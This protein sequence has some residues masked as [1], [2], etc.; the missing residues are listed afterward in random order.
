M[1]QGTVKWFNADKGFGFIEQEGGDDVFVHFSAIQGEG[2]K[3]LD[4]GQ[5]VTFDIEQGQ[6]GPQATNVRK[7]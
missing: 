7:A 5:K 2:F 6:R 3:S 1:E 4:E